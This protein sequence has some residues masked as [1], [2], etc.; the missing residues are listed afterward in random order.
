MRRFTVLG[1]ALLIVALAACGSSGSG[2]AADSTSGSTS[3]TTSTPTLAPV[4]T[5]STTIDPTAPTI[6]VTPS[7]GLTDGQ[8]VNVTGKNWTAGTKIGITECLDKGDA[9]GA[10]DCN[11]AGIAPTIQTVPADGTYSGQYAV[12]LKPS[13]AGDPCSATVPCVMSLGQLVE[14]DTPHP[15]VSITFAG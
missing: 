6:E 2:K 3:Q 11:L 8:M 9:T 13:T 14:G 7:T 12:K 5:T 10:A 1:T 15:S 4:T